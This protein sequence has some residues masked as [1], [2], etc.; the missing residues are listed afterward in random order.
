[1]NEMM[2]DIETFGTRPGS[3]IVSI[4]AVVF[5]SGADGLGPEFYANVEARSC[6]MR[7]MTTDEATL[8]FW[9]LPENKRALSR[10]STKPKPIDLAMALKRLSHF[11]ED[12]DCS[13]IWG[14][15]CAFD[16]VLVEE[17]M[18]KC[19]VEFPW[20]FRDLRDTRTLFDLV[21]TFPDRDLGRY[22]K[23]EALA[24]AKYQA[25]CVQHVRATLARLHG[26]EAV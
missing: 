19:D 9:A 6:G 22:P 15:G 12:N 3:V 20:R 5:D 21:E 16:V 18:R 8:K 1:M 25:V 14:H 2:L 7:G 10:L 4:G 11:Y 13:R 17:A 23:H 26:M 24:D